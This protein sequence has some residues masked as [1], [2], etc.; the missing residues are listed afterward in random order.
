M[1][2]T[3]PPGQWVT[4]CRVE[5]IPLEDVKRFDIGNRTF[6]II[7]SPEGEFFAMDGHCSHE[8]VHLAGGLVDGGIIECPLHF[9][10]F[11]YRTGE[12]LKLPACVDLRT[13]PVRVENED[14]LILV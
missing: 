4:A 7:R 11:N 12:S 2:S 10:T 3:N 1:N 5:D 8:K 13:Y 14:V 6:V 9:G